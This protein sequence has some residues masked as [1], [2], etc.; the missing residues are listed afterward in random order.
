MEKIVAFIKSHDFKAEI[1]EGVVFGEMAFSVKNGPV[2]YEWE[3]VGTTMN[4]A[5]NWLGY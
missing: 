3:R 5:R 4:D 1:R 2:Q